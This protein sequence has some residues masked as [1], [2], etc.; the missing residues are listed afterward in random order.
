MSTDPLEVIIHQLSKPKEYRIHYQCQPRPFVRCLPVLGP[1]RTRSR[2]IGLNA[3]RPRVE[4]PPCKMRPSMLFFFTE[5]LFKKE[6]AAM[7]RLRNPQAI[8]FLA[9]FILVLPAATASEESQASSSWLKDF[10]E[11]L[12]LAR[13]TG[14]PL[15]AVIR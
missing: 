9:S 12:R 15:F 11:G 14:K 7:N 8:A 6:F 1:L 4:S 5:T 13:S 2:R 10:N 3:A